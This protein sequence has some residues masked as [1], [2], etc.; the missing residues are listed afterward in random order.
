[1]SKKSEHDPKL[2]HAVKEVLVLQTKSIPPRTF[3]IAAGENRTGLT[4]PRLVP[5]E[6]AS[7]PEVLDLDFQVDHGAIEVI[8]GASAVLEIELNG[9]KNEVTV[10][11]ATNSITQAATPGGKAR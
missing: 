3:V 1:M 2:I 9:G 8:T 7:I 10:H 5:S 6:R 11:A 4:N